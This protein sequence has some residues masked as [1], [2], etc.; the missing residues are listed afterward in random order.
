MPLPTFAALL[1]F[2]IAAAGATIALAT[3][4]GMLGALSLA[5]LLAAAALQSIR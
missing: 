2:V 3:A 4:S 5:A 1:G